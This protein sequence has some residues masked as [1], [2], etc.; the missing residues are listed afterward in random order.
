M[1]ID[2]SPTAQQLLNEQMARGGFSSPSDLVEQALRL[3]G[4]HTTKE[5]SIAAL[6]E[7]AAEM[8]AGETVPAD[9][10]FEEIRSRHG[11]TS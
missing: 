7:S 11:W 8:E 4:F 2:L 1:S 5:E 6:R 10:V 3:Y 9:Q